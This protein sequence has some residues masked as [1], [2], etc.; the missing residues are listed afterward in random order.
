[1][2]QTTA[3][4]STVGLPPAAVTI[5]RRAKDPLK[6]VLWMGVAVV[7]FSLIAIGGR[8]ASEGP[9]KVGGFS[10]LEI[11][12]WRSIL[13]VLIILAIILFTRQRFADLI[14]KQP[15]VS[16]ARA[17]I[18]GIAQ[19]L[20][21]AALLLM[22]LAELFALE[23]T[24][25]L[26]VALLAPFL[27]GEKLTATRVVAAVVGFIGLLI[28]VRPGFQSFSTGAIYALLSAL[29]FALSMISTRQLTKTDGA[30]T[31]LFAMLG[32]QLLL[33][34]VITPA[35]YGLRW[36]GTT[37]AFWTGIVGLG[38]LAAH[39][40][41][42]RA[43]AYGDAMIVAPMD[44]IRLPVIMLAAYLIYQETLSIYVAIGGSVVIMANV[45]NMW[46]ERRQK[47]AVAQPK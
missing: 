23:F 34:I 12:T 21:F 1:M 25:P 39:Y 37:A 28:V 35:I 20:W 9:G 5:D 45:I 11:M 47:T 31:I 33:L 43:F 32:L 18:H 8:E 44:F 6:A 3:P 15:A 29:G 14:T 41:L 7:S 10:T 30:F 26:W 22:P 4:A 36:P 46:G 27:L 40:G 19:Y 24:S 17:G 38:A 42:A 2:S 13:G 16:I